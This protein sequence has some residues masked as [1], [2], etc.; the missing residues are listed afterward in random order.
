M[1]Y[2]PK[3]VNKHQNVFLS[4]PATRNSSPILAHVPFKPYGVGTSRK[5][6]KVAD[7]RCSSILVIQELIHEDV[8]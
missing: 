5:Q 2:R 8:Y 4:D 3:Y 6:I 7:N 1:A